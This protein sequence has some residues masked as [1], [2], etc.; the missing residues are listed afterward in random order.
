MGLGSSAAKTLHLL[1]AEGHSSLQRGEDKWDGS[2]GRAGAGN[3]EQ[4]PAASLGWW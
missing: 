4:L 3:T 1:S 2:P